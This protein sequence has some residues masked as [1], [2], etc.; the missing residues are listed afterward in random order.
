MTQHGGQGPETGSSEAQLSETIRLQRP[1][2]GGAQAPLDVTLTSTIL[3]EV[4]LKHPLIR[5]VLDFIVGADDFT[6]ALSRLL[7]LGD[8]TAA[9]DL[10]EGSGSHSLGQS[11]AGQGV[12]T[13]ANDAKG[14]PIRLLKEGEAFVGW[15]RAKTARLRAQG[16]TLVLAEALLRIG[17]EYRPSLPIVSAAF[18]SQF[19]SVRDA[20]A[21]ARALNYYWSG[22]YD[23]AS[24]VALPSIEAVVRSI[25]EEATGDS[26][27]DPQR[28]RDGHESA[29]GVLIARLEGCLLESFRQELRTVLTDPIGLNLRNIHLH[30]VAPTESRHDAAVILYTAARLTLIS[31]RR[32]TSPS[33]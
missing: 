32:T 29:L 2:V 16:F 7:T 15:E 25:V 26:Y 20:A 27:V 19:I 6:S 30:G 1:D 28:T 17:Q 4:D 8:V 24:R 10:P 5:E 33:D 23:D 9:P 12:P 14:R 11:W 31:A 21:F 18:R 22:H 3:L 13:A